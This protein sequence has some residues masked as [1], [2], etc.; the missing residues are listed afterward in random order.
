MTE[1]KTEY[2]KP[3][4]LQETIDGLNIDPAGI[5]VDVTFGA[6][7]HSREILKRLDTG[8][9]FA[10]DR[11]ADALSNQISD[12]R[13]VLINH[14]F[15][16]LK[17]FLRYHNAIPVDGILADLGVSFHQ[18]DTSERGFSFRFDARLDMR[19]DQEN[20]LSAWTVVNTYPEAR[21]QKIFGMYGEV[22]NAKTLAQSIVQARKQKHIDTTGEL[23]EI[24]KKCMRKSDKE[25]QYLSTVFQAIRIEVNNEIEGLKQLLASCAEVLKPGG[26]L[27]VLSY[28]SIE[29]RLVKKLQNMNLN[30]EVDL[31]GNKSFVFKTITKKP[32]V[33]SAEEVERNPRARS[34]KLRILE[35]N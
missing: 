5:Y 30:D 27:V 21:L 25:N 22:K 19:M 6:G 8:K 34:A 3:A 29:D 15:I 11:D 35:K 32:L 10:F 28:H 1:A 4:L 7:G 23:V 2:H 9:L 31:Y 17:R 18:F 20:E 24:V 14:D 16:Y 13:F 12:D 33:A 26:R